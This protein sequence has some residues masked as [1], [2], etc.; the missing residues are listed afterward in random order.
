[1]FVSLM[2]TGIKKHWWSNLSRLGKQKRKT[3]TT[4]TTTKYLIAVKSGFMGMK[5]CL[6]REIFFAILT[7]FLNET[8]CYVKLFGRFSD[9]KTEVA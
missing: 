1:M 2:L 4:T 5:A 9:P 7:L 3:T 8:A 6:P